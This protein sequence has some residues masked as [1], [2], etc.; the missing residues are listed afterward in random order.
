VFFEDQA[1]SQQ[2]N[3]YLRWDVK[4]GFRINSSRK[5]VSHQF[6]LDLQNVTNRENDFAQRYSPNTNQINT[7]SQIGFFPDVM[8]RIQ[9]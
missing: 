4:V 2:L 6:F 9:F 8:Y 3:D 5:K 1:F 7:V